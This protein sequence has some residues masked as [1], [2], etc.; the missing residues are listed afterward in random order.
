[1][2][3]KYVVIGISLFFLLMCFSV[4]GGVDDNKF[5]T[6]LTLENATILVGQNATLKAVITED[7]GTVLSNETI[8]FYLD[9]KVVGTSKTNKGGIATL[10]INTPTEGIHDIR[11]QFSGTA[12]YISSSANAKLNVSKISTILTLDDAKSLVGQN[13]T[14]KAVLK[15]EKGSVLGGD[16]T[17][18]QNGKAIGTVKAPSTGDKV[19]IVTLTIPTPTRGT[20][21][22]Y[23]QFNATDK[24]SASVAKAKLY[25]S[26]PIVPD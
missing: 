13:A 6:I 4:Y 11:V 9:N 19:G 24:Y 20:Y 25:V 22:I 5:S 7:D 18:Y 26:Y 12:L 8:T 16:I 10:T 14:L 1:M 21:N 15:D 3:N 17:F 23:A 2:K